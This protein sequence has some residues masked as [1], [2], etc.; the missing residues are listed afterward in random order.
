MALG[1]KESDSNRNN[2]LSIDLPT[3]GS[4]PTQKLISTLLSAGVPQ[5]VGYQ[6]TDKPTYFR[7]G[8]AF[9]LT[10]KFPTPTK[11]HVIWAP[12]VYQL[13]SEEKAAEAN[14][15]PDSAFLLSF[16]V[17]INSIINRIIEREWLVGHE[18][19][20]ALNY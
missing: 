10:G 5:R 11:I 1:F 4:Y 14:P 2:A 20:I 19:G 13:I 7:R 16:P 9:P 3:E 17:T 8:I 15:K 18:T 12:P 6:N